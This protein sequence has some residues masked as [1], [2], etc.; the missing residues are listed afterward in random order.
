[1]GIDEAS[2]ER[3]ARSNGCVWEDDIYYVLRSD[4]VL[5]GAS[6]CHNQGVWNPVWPYVMNERA[7]VMSCCRG[8]TRDKNSV[9]ELRYSRKQPHHA[10]VNGSGISGIIPTG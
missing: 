8:G 1:M 3:S 4:R 9:T 5:I 7:R 2:M 10:T 6:D